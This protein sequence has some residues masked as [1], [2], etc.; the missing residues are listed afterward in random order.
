M[1]QTKTFQRGIQN[2]GRITVGKFLTRIITIIVGHK[3]DKRKKPRFKRKKMLKKTKIGYLV[4]ICPSCD[5]CANQGWMIDHEQKCIGC[6]NYSKFVDFDGNPK[7]K[8]EE[9]E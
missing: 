3:I 5:I 9:L 2:V 8:G 4:E 7:W 1:V 6:S